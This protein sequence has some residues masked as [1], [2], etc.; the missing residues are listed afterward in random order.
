M[1]SPRAKRVRFSGKPARQISPRPAR[2]NDLRPVFQK[3]RPAALHA[4]PPGARRPKHHPPRPPPDH[5]PLLLIAP[6][7]ANIL[8]ELAHGLAGNPLC[9]I[10]LAYF[11]DGQTGRRGTKHRPPCQAQGLSAF[12]AG[13]FSKSDRKAWP[14]KARAVKS[15][16]SFGSVEARAGHL[17]MLQTHRAA[18]RHAPRPCDLSV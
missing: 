16:G 5:A 11:P 12:P 6:A 9:E 8:A 4:P 10:A 2:R 18:S 14:V 17:R 15:V 13:R 1:S 3:A 7:T